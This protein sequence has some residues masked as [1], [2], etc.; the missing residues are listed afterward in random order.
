MTTTATVQST[1]TFRT[2]EAYI[3]GG[4]CGHLWMPSALAGQTIRKS[5]RG[6][7]GIMDRFTEPASFRDALLSLLCEDGGDFQDARFTADTEIVI[8]RERVIG[9]GRRELHTRTRTIAE[10]ADCA[11]LVDAEH[12]TGDFLPDFE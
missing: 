6:P 3:S 7:F 1:T 8:I 4:I 12:C 11:D 5:L 10:L 9:N 2:R